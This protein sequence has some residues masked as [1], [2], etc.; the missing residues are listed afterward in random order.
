[1]PSNSNPLKI[2]ATQRWGGTVTFSGPTSQEREA[3]AA[4]VV[5]ATGAVLVPPY[6]HPAIMTGQGTVGLE[7]LAQ[8]AIARDD[9]P[10]DIPPLDV[11]I[12]PCSG[13]GLLSGIALACHGTGVRVFGAE[14]EEG[15]ADDC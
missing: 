2:A 12:A 10:P 15:G 11:V 1:M 13:G 14:P 3:A 4:S 6:D 5:E 9:A 8:A 7:M